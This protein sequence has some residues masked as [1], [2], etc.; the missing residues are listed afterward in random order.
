MFHRIAFIFGYL[1]AKTKK[2]KN[3][4][5]K[6]KPYIFLKFNTKEVYISFLTL[7]WILALLSENL[8]QKG[9]DLKKKSN[10]VILHTFLNGLGNFGFSKIEKCV[11]NL[12]SFRLHSTDN[13]RW[14]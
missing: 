4:Q 6:K 7:N 10:E 13:Y 2:K 12:A 9:T 5:T 3:K 8:P 1:V 14:T 11:P